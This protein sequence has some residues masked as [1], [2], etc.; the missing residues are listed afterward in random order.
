MIYHLLYP[1][2]AYFTPLNMLGYISFRA[3]SAA[4][5]AILIAFIFGKPII[6]FLSR[7]SF[8]EVIRSDGPS[9]HLKK[10]GTPTMGGLLIHL[11]VLI[12]TLLWADLSNRFI[13][14]VIMATVWMGVIGFLDDY[15]KIKKRDKK[16]ISPRAKLLAQSALGLVVGALIFYHP[17]N[18]ELSGATIV[19]F[20]KS[21]SINLGVFYIL[22]AMLVI[23]G[24]SNAVNL[25]DGLDGLA[26]GLMSIVAGA[27][28]IIA[29]IA[30]RI[31]F[32][33]YLNIPYLPG[34]GELAI[35][36]AAMFG[37]LLGF[38]WYNAKPAEV[39]MGD[40]GSL[41]FGAAIG[42]SAVLLKQEF[43]LFII[44][45]VFV[46]ETVSVMLQVS[47][48]KFTKKR[49]GAGRRIFKMAPIH[50]H[51]E[52]KG[53]EE[54]KVVIRFWIL[55]ILFALMALSTFKIR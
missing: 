12:P 33:S 14:L 1:L 9:S 16:G 31:D 23:N 46:L 30:G 40:V 55:G 39:F 10:Q 7:L 49:M 54:S 11:S 25:T 15:H 5:T 17:V 38:L 26:T 37:G 42:T 6:G 29:Y 44:G 22:F 4:I 50:H 51:F 3:S 45:G 2:K 28:A 35:F 47:W 19:P 32:S 41:A 20:F 43:L 13:Q 52:L 53:W 24:T 48:F 36:L 34:A 8:S 18:P 27:L 21:L